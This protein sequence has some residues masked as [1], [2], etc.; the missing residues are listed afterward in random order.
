MGTHEPFDRLVRAVDAWAART[1]RGA[2]V[3]GQIT[4]RAGYRPKHFPCAAA[5]A[6]QDY[7][8]RLR[9]ATLVVS[10]AG[11][12]SILT[13]LGSG[14]PIVVMPRRGH[15]GETRNDHQN[16]TVARLGAR[17]GLHVAADETALG[18][19][20]DRLADGAAPPDPIGAFAEDSLISAIRGLIEGR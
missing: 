12:G 4:A 2:E 10:H 19:L 1:G 11:M 14:T 7:E 3:F 15:L 6:P 18:P 17:P 5:L 9:S 13:A 20:L 16:D 8:A